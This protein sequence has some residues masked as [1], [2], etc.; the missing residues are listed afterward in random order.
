MSLVIHASASKRWVTLGRVDHREPTVSAS[1]WPGVATTTGTRTPPRGRLSVTVDTVTSVSRVRPLPTVCLVEDS[2]L[3]AKAVTEIL[4]TAGYG[5][6]GVFGNA[7]TAM[8]SFSSS[9]PEVAIVDIHLPD[10]SGIDVAR[11]LLAAHHESRA[12]L[13]SDYNHLDE[14]E[15]L[16]RPDRLR[17]SYLLKSSVGSREGFLFSFAAAY[18]FSVIDPRLSR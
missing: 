9:P 16:P 15:A 5:V 6:T 8:D 4:Q 11:A 7:R 12:V 2:S 10:G 14:V 13:F 17:L 3:F 18:Q 1:Q